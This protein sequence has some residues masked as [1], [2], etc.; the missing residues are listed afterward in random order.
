M[1]E[2]TVSM[3]FVCEPELR[4]AFVDLCRADDRPA[5]QVLRSLMREYL[6]KKSQGRLPLKNVGGNGA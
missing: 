6:E 3:T 5:S 2:K 4:K 1:A